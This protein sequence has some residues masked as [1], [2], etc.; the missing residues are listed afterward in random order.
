MKNSTPNKIK[1]LH[2]I[3]GDLWAGAEVMAFNLIRSLSE[4]SDLDISIILLNEGKLAEELRNCGLEVHVIDERS[5]SFWKI[6]R[7]ALELINEKNPDIIHAHRYKENLLALFIS[8]SCRRIKLI[9]TQHGL[10]EITGA[11]IS[12]VAGLKSKLNFHILSRYF[13]KTVAVS[14]DIRN[15][16]ISR[17]GFAD[18]SIEVIH[19]GIHLPPSPSYPKLLDRPFVI[20]S[21]G[22]L[23]PVKDYPLMVE[24]AHNIALSGKA[25]IRFELAGDGPE[26]TQL[27]NLIR[28]DGLQE[29]FILKGHQDD[30][31]SFY[32]GLNIY[33]NTSVHEGIPMTILEA[34]AHGLPVIAPAVGGI[35]EIYSDGVEGFLI[36][37]RDPQ[38]FAV[39]CLQL[40]KDRAMRE[41]MSKAAR[42]RA[43][44]A[45]SAEKMSAS[46]Y[47]IYLE[48][49][50][51]KVNL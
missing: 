14:N 50:N 48:A 20:G 18:E 34:M 51:K 27:E 21:S 17:F 28:R 19:N 26:R 25:N 7:K 38:E 47:R 8:K 45:F 44:L 24:I 31:D 35:G 22:R 42:E 37:G 23:F 49:R 29:N 11:N 41:R 43:E 13:A 46:Y 15:T 6:F 5:Y 30:M 10:P 1:V 12:L 3:S 2:L 36:K 40:F 32:L 4:S 16:L 33:I 9:A 39:K